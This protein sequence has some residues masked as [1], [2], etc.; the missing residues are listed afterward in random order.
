MI[1][2]NLAHDAPEITAARIPLAELLP[3]DV[4][5]V[6]AGASGPFIYEVQLGEGVN[7]LLDEWQAADLVSA[8][9]R[10]GLSV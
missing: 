9:Q 3:P 2:I 5:E 7:L 6:H 8:L 4:T 1:Q 10:T